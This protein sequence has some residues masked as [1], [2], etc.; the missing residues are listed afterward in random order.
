LQPRAAELATLCRGVI[1][2]FATHER[3]GQITLTTRGN[4]TGNWDTDLLWQA[5][6][7]LISNALHHGAQDSPIT[8]DVNADSPNWIRLT[9][10]NRGM[11]PAGVLP[12]LFEAF[13]SNAAGERSRE[14]LGLGLHIVHKIVHMHGG[15]VVGKSDEVVGTVFTVDLPRTA[16]SWVG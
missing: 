8:V 2:E 3:A 7:N 15:K 6:S 4:S 9:V 16:Q 5:I 14:G 13:G 12:H 11:I 10:T 1:E